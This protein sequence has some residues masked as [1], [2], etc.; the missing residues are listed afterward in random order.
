[1]LLENVETRLGKRKSQREFMILR[2]RSLFNP[3]LG[4]RKSF[5][6]LEMSLNW[7]GSLF[8]NIPF[9]TYLHGAGAPLTNVVAWTNARSTANIIRYDLIA[10]E[11]GGNPRIEQETRRQY[12]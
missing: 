12:I 2:S 1:M 5:Y 8:K 7:I 11:F 3:F 6:K 10:F 9:K 4:G